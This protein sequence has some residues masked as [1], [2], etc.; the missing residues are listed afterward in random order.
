MLRRVRQAR[1]S[2]DHFLEKSSVELGGVRFLGATPWTDF[3]LFGKDRQEEAMA[4]AE[5]CMNDYRVISVAR[6]GPTRVPLS[7]RDAL[8]FF[9]KSSAW[10]E[11]RLAEPFDGPTVVVTHHLSAWGSVSTRHRDDL[12]TAAFASDLSPLVE[13]Y[14]PALW[15]HG[16]THEACDY[17]IGQ[18]RIVCNPRGY[19]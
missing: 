15:I 1:T 14:Q 12:V 9:G 4:A 19:P 3:V 13:R 6:D 16:Q 11:R 10:L 17:L 7:A 2:S 18:T 5:R 8:R